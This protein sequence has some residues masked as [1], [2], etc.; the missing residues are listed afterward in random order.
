MAVPLTVL[1][2][3]PY[4]SPKGAV[5]SISGPELNASPGKKGR[6]ARGCC[7]IGF[8]GGIET[9]SASSSGRK[10]SLK[11]A[12]TLAMC[13]ASDCTRFSLRWSSSLGCAGADASAILG[14]L[15]SPASL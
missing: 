12:I 11:D 1:C 6:A 3:R 2:A 7:A 15:D 14:Y 8:G 9:D 5:M 4:G 13:I 10:G